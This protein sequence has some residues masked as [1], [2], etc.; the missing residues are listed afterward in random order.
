[1]P[2]GRKAETE[3]NLRKDEICFFR[4]QD[5][6]VLILMQQ[7]QQGFGEAGEIPLGDVWLVAI[8]VAATRSMELNTVAGS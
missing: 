2:A 8:G 7:R 6:F 1:M 3:E 5:C 4:K